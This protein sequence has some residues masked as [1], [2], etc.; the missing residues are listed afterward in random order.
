VPASSALIVEALLRKSTSPA[1]RTEAVPLQAAIERDD[2]A[3]MVAIFKMLVGNI[4]PGLGVTP[5][6]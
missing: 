5:P 4:C 1:M 2:E 6:T 3:K